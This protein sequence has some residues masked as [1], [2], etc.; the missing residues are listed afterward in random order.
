M[1]RWWP[2][3][4]WADARSDSVC[5][6]SLSEAALDAAAP[7]G[8]PGDPALGPTLINDDTQATAIFVFAGVTLRLDFDCGQIFLNP[9]SCHRIPQ[10]E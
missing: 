4:G 9:R 2:K 10:S 6:R 7:Y 1:G 3:A 5:P 8:D